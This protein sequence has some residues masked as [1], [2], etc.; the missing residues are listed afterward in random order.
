MEWVE[1]TGRSVE[2]AMTAA[3]D[4]LGVDESEIDFEV[5]EEPKTGM[6]GRTKREARI[7]VRVKPNIPRSKDAA[8]RT[9]RR[10]ER[11]GGSSERTSTSNERPTASNSSTHSSS[12]GRGRS[13]AASIN[14]EKNNYEKSDVVEERETPAREVSNERN[15][16]RV[17]TKMTEEDYQDEVEEAIPL[18]DQAGAA[19]EFLAGLMREFHIPGQ[20]SVSSMEDDQ[21]SIDITGDANFG[22]LIGPK[23]LVMASVQELARAS[24][25]NRFRRANARINVDIAGFRER[26]RTSLEAFAI[27]VANQ[28]K[29]SDRQK[30]LEAM[31]SSDRKIV[32]DV[33]NDM[34]GIFTRSEGR[35]PRRY[36]VVS[37]RPW[38]SNGDSEDFD[39]DRDR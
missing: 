11:P 5:L 30:A 33:L 29:V 37:P 39:R 15:G 1:T 6:F 36:V 3:L 8:R 27:S 28:V 10:R 38:E 17:P 19:Q 24:V 25:Q 7:R 35:E 4:L 14:N 23:G 9:R 2:E 12:N 34:E 26:R 16:R 31:N 18:V 13:E 32:H 21:I 22:L 20:I